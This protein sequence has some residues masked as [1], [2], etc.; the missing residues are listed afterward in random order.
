M[1]SPIMHKFSA[2]VSQSSG[3]RCAPTA[4]CFL[5]LLGVLHEYACGALGV[6]ACGSHA[7]SGRRLRHF[8]TKTYAQSG[9]VLDRMPETVRKTSIMGV[10]F[11]GF[12]ALS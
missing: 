12:V 4:L 11:L 10:T 7:L 2:T 6:P 3:V 1:H 8:A 9:L 5:A